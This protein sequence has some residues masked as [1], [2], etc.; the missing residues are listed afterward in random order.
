MKEDTLFGV[1]EL[2]DEACKRY[3]VTTVPADARAVSGPSVAHTALVGRR[4][5][6]G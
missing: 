3:T 6:R 2:V 4:P 5:V 1:P